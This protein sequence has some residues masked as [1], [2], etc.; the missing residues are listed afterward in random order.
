LILLWFPEEVSLRL[1]QVEYDLFKQVPPAEYLRHATL[2]MNNHKSG[3]GGGR[4]S[5]KCA[6]SDRE[7]Q[8]GELVDQEADPVA[9]VGREA[10]G[11][12]SVGDQVLNYVL[13]HGKLQFVA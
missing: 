12:H 3:G 2:D 8:G 11:D 5:A 7:V 4:V 1:T 9:T 6:G 13:E 10:A